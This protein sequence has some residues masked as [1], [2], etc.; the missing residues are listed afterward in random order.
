MAE[1]RVDAASQ[2][3]LEDAGDT[4]LDRANRRVPLELGT[5]RDSG[6]VI[7]DGDRAVVSYDT[8]YAAYLHEHPEYNFQNGRE[9]KWLANAV[10]TAG[11]DVL[12]SLARGLRRAF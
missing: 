1:A 5:L 4:L 8:A 6:R 9:G 7:S 2:P 10:N 12:A 11:P 3:A